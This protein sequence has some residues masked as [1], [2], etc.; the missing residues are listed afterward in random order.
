MAFDILNVGSTE[1]GTDESRQCVGRERLLNPLAAA[2]IY[3][4]Q[5]L[6]QQRLCKD[7]LVDLAAGH[8]VLPR[9]W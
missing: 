6:G 9:R 8:F 3:L 5:F 2:L 4:D 1:P 7:L